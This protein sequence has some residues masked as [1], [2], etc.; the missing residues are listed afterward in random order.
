[1]IIASSDETSWNQR[2]LMFTVCNVPQPV[3]HVNTANAAPGGAFS[4]CPAE[5]IANTIVLLPRCPEDS[6]QT[7]PL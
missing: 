7:Q 3:G 2:L 6:C 5:S 4:G 1:M